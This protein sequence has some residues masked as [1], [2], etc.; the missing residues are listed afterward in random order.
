MK[1]LPIGKQDFARLINEGYI[2]V[3]KTDYIQRLISTGSVYFLSRPR[4]FGKSLTVSTLKEIFSG[5]KELFRGL[6]IYDKIEWKKYPVIHFDFSKIID[7]SK[8]FSKSLNLALNNLAVQSGLK[9]KGTTE[10]EKF[11]EIIQALGKDEQVAILIDEY[12]KPIIDYLHDI[13]KAKEHRDILKNLFSCLKGLDAC[14][15]FLF[16]TGVSKFSKVSIFSD[17]NHLDDITLSENYAE[18]LGYSEKDIIIYFQEYLEEIKKRNGWDEE[19]IIAELRGYYNGYSWN[20]NRERVYNPFSVLKFFNERAFKNYWFSTGTPTFLI[21]AIKNRKELPEKTGNIL[22]GEAFFDKFEIE[23]ID[24]Y[25]L[26]FQSGYLTIKDTDGFGGYR[27]GYPNREV[28]Q[29]FLS[30][31]ME[32]YSHSYLSETTQ[33]IQYITR[34]L[35]YNDWDSIIKQL[36]ILFSSVP[37]PLFRADSEFYYHSIIHTALSLVGVDLHSELQTSTGRIDTVIK[38]EKYIYIVEFKMGAA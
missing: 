8:P 37:Y 4:R 28:E 21:N 34:G 26:M 36:N 15:K 20:L 14:I 12:D 30:Q 24:I 16:I 5:N 29:S 17:L 9:L 10:K 1:K 7:K 33:A 19:K 25:S 23:H 13:E 18:M 6:W 38:T 35:H 3:D 32:A 11:D 31:L 27:L 2:Y 22:V